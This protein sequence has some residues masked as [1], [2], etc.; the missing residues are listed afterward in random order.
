MDAERRKAARRQADRDMIHQLQ[1]TRRK[2]E[3]A[4]QEVRHLRRRA[5]RHNCKVNIGLKAVYA[6]GGGDTWNAEEFP[7]SGR[8]LD[9]SPEGCSIFSRDQM[10]IGQTP[11]LVIEIRKGGTI[12]A[13]GVIRW[14]KHVREHN[15]F[16]SGVQFSNITTRDQQR[17]TTFLHDLDENIGL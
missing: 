4:S 12:R 7:L 3:D 5:V 11:S 17:I 2:K 10:D 13:E 1:E 16:A 14:S 6:S 8:I 15:G 9:L